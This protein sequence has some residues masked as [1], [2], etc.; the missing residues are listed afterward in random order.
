LPTFLLYEAINAGTL[1][2]LMADHDWSELDIFAVYPKTTILPRRTRAFVDFMAW[3][4]DKNP[5][6]NQIEPKA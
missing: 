1:V 2:P 5:H 3:R 6:W 4:F